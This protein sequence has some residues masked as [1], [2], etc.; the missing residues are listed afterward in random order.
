MDLRKPRLHQCAARQWVTPN[1]RWRVECSVTSD[2]GLESIEIWDG[3]DLFARIRPNGEKRFHHVFELSHRQMQQLMLVVK[4]AKGRTAYCGAVQDGNHT[5]QHYFCA[6][7]INGGLFHGPY[8]DPRMVW[9]V[10]PGRM[11]QTNGY[12]GTDG[13]AADFCRGDRPELDLGV[14]ETRSAGLAAAIAAFTWS[15]TMLIYGASPATIAIRRPRRSSTPGTPMVR[16]WSARVRQRSALTW[17]GVAG[18]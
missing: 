15:M 4:D 18:C 14:R 6:D 8:G 1:Y 16:W 17:R 10:L 11:F 7:R 5:S 3:M 9:G 2:T 13:A 12:D